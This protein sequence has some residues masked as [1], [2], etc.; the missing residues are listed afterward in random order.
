MMCFKSKSSFDFSKIVSPSIKLGITIVLYPYPLMKRCDWFV[1]LS[2]YEGTPVTID[3]AMILGVPVIATDVGGIT[4]QMGRYK[5]GVVL[6][7]GTLFI[8]FFFIYSSHS[9][10]MTFGIV[11]F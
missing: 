11:P 2:Q 7:S 1:L 6:K 9:N 5:K 10:D 3:E 8:C 4:E